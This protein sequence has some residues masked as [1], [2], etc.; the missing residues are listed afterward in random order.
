MELRKIRKRIAEEASIRQ[1]HIHDEATAKVDDAAAQIFENNEKRLS[2]ETA[3]Y[4]AL[5]NEKVGRKELDDY[6]DA[7]STL[8]FEASKLL[9][10]E[11]RA[12]K[13]LEIEEHKTREA[14]AVLRAKLQQHDKLRILF[15]K[16]SQ[17]R[18]RQTN[19]LA[20]LED[21]DQRRPSPITRRGS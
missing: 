15:E 14:N 16:Q 19:L 9:R 18:N 2:R 3:L 6:L 10:E 1:Q 7:L 11:E 20:E 17:A 21:E 12:R 13:D 4:N 5:S 8:D